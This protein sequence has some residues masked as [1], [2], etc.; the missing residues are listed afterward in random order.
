MLKDNLYY[1]YTIIAK[2][3]SF[4]MENLNILQDILQTLKMLTYKNKLRLFTD[5]FSSYFKF[6][7]LY[8]LRW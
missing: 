6:I 4:S 1:K 8:A 7:N 3:Q 5:Q 2:K